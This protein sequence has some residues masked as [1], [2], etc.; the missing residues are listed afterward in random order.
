[1]LLK[2]QMFEILNLKYGIIC[3]IVVLCTVT[4]FRHF[5][6]APQRLE[7]NASMF[8]SVKELREGV[9]DI[10]EKLSTADIF[11]FLQLI[12]KL[13][14]SKKIDL[15]IMENLSLSKMSI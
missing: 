5:L 2:Y 1:M 10:I 11:A 7:D 14:L 8:R 4:T 3:T 6:L 13:S 15:G 9:G 12:G